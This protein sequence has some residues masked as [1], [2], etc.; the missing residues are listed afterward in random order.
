[1]GVAP[2]VAAAAIGHLRRRKWSDRVDAL[3]EGCDASKL[4]K[5]A[6]LRRRL[7]QRFGLSN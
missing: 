5:G 1:M 4:S 2:L 7:R 3:M 6:R